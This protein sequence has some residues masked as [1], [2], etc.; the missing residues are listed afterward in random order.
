MGLRWTFQ[1]SLCVVN[2]VPLTPRKV[3]R[4]AVKMLDSGW[5]LP[6]VSW[7]RLGGED[8]S[9]SG[10]FWNMIAGEMGWGEWECHREEN[11]ARLLLWPAAGSSETC[12]SVIPLH[13]VGSQLLVSV[14]HRLVA[15]SGEREFP[16]LTWEVQE[17][18]KPGNGG[19][20]LEV[21]E[22]VV[23]CTEAQTGQKLLLQTG[24]QLRG[25]Y[26]FIK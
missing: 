14:S 13:G 26:I 15:A 16:Y 12:S 18:R 19:Q 25:S 17:N 22:E 23:M 7:R 9:R 10:L 3:P 11:G 4:D 20:Q 21:C 5:P 1:N 6:S 2:K 24:I 8:F